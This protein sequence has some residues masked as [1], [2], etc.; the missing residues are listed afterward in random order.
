MSV[1]GGEKK[2]VGCKDIKIVEEFYTS[3]RTDDGLNKYCKHCCKVNRACEGVR[4]RDKKSKLSVRQE[5]RAKSQ[6]I[7]YE[8]GIKLV[9]IFKRD[10]GLCG[11]CGLWVAPKHASMD[12]V[13]AISRGGTHIM[14]NLQLS[15]LKCNLR[16]GNR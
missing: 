10:L 6:G 5:Q 3:S 8:A 9:N 1:R 4:K 2:C 12:H 15:H 7:I 14:G 13:L 11:I 16:K